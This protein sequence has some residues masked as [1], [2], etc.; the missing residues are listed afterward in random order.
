MREP[1]ELTAEEAASLLNVR[2]A[3]T[4]IQYYKRGWLEGR[5]EWAG[6]VKRYFFTQEAIQRCLDRL[7]QERGG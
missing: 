1:G 2:S 6:I 4:V 5:Y 7:Q 3:E